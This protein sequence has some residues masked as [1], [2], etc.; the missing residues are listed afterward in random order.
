MKN[1][2]Y[3]PNLRKILVNYGEE[4]HI[5]GYIEKHNINLAHKLIEELIANQV[6]EAY[7][8][9][10]IDGGINVITEGKS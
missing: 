1:T 4:C 10:Y 6:E 9:G 3:K 5:H 8:K 7:K 2:E